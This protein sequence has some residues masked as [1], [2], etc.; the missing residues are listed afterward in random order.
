MLEPTSRSGR[1]AKHKLLIPVGTVTQD[2]Q[3]WWKH[4][5]TTW[6]EAAEGSA[7]KMM[8]QQIRV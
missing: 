3:K 6:K 4:L 8:A 2:V 1:L 7:E 5:R